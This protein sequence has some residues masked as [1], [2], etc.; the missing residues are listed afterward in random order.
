MNIQNQYLLFLDLDGVLV[1]FEKGVEGIFNKS[2]HQLSPKQMWPKLARTPDF[3]TTLEWMPD[4]IQLWTFCE[5][6]QP[7]ILTGL[8]IGKWAEPQ[9]R[10]WCAA[11]LGEDTEVIACL[12]K[13]KA[14][15]ARKR[16]PNRTPVLIDDR[17][18][19]RTSW[20]EMG[21]IFIHHTNAQTSIDALENL[22]F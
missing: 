14:A 13:Q 6:Y 5:P 18:S 17:S 10:Q 4:G 22:G 3:Y 7:I 1:D 12:S 16:D 20:E 11:Q 15:N 21:G 19:L 8:P 2:I 9:K